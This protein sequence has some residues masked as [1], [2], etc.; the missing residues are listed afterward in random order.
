MRIDF[1]KDCIGCGACVGACPEVFEFDTDVYKVK[2]NIGADFSQ[3]MA[4]IREAADI[5]PA[6]SYTHLDVYKRQL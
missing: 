3:H 4:A 6:V 2:V 1:G 5:C